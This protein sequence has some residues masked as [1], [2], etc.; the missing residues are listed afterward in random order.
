MSEK[1]KGTFVVLRSAGLG[2]RIKSYVSHL[3]RWETVKVEHPADA[4]LFKKLD[5]ASK[6]DI[7]EYPNTGSV[8]RLLVDEDEENEIDK[9]KSIDFLYEKTPNYFKEK[10]LPIF[11]SLEFNDDVVNMVND[12]SSEWNCWEMIGINI[13][14]TTSSFNRDKF[15]DLE[16]FE[17]IVDGFDINQKFYFCSDSIPIRKYYK[18]K[19]GD[20]CISLDIHEIVDTG[21]TFDYTQSLEALVE[22]L[23]LS[24]CKK[25]L[26]LTNGSTFGECAWWFGGCETEVYCPTIIENVSKEWEDAHFIKK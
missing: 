11:K 3:A 15:V 25:K 2:N 4:Q 5:L 18:N 19:Y 14:A 1:N 24:K 26:Y 23:L 6:D 17:K 22:I 16:G 7:F 8:W 20:R 13:R 10:Y 21:F 12:I 9:Y